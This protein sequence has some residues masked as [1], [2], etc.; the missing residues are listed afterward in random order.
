MRVICP[1]FAYSPV[2]S[3]VNRLVFLQQ[4]DGALSWALVFDRKKMHV[5]YD[6]PQLVLVD[7]RQ[8][9]EL[10]DADILFRNV[11][12]KRFRHTANCMRDLETEL[13]FHVARS[14]RFTAFYAIFLDI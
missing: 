2:L 8:S 10:L 14:R 4:G 6:A 1:D 11:I 3:T 12:G 7:R 9:G 13:L 5:A